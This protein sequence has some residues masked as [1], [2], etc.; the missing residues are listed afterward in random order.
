MS[1]LPYIRLEPYLG[2]ESV[3]RRFS[4]LLAGLIVASFTAALLL[5]LSGHDPIKAIYALGRGA[6]GSANALSGTL[7]KSVPIAL[8]AIGIAIANR[9]RIWN[10]GAEGQLYFGAF[11]ATGVGLSLPAEMAA[12]QAVAL[13]LLAGVAGGAG[14]AMIA[15][16]LRA[17][18]HVNEILSTLMLNY[19]AILWV[20]YLVTGPWADPATFS[21][22]YSAP[23]AA[24]AQ[25]GKVFGNA[26]AGI[27]IVLLAVGLLIVIDRGSRLGYELKVT[28]DAPQAAKYAGISSSGMVMVALTLAG[29]LA[30]L[31][32][33]IEVA[34]STTRLQAG[35]SPGYG[36]MAIMVAALAGSRPVPILL[37]SILYA[38]LLNGGFSLQVS[39][40]PPSVSTIIQAI[41]L[42]AI[43]GAA[44]LARY[45]VRILRRIESG[46]MNRA[47][48]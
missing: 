10:I 7:N 13:V 32:G 41:L 29:A 46:R 26:H 23:I 14:W 20:N 18:L 1:G 33:A 31:A 22:P 48:A 2:R 36:F 15:G 34:G 30:G 16:W 9:A 3:L 38:G 6:F 12:S 17:F 8:C 35:L 37:C 44:T 39:G 21:L 24:T 19:I 40:I 42:L 45:R 4:F 5:L 47:G 27:L 28:G 11:A 43:L 25:L